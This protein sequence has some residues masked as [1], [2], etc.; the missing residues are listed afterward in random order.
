MSVVKS[1]IPGNRCAVDKTIE[2]TFM[3]LAKLNS[4]AIGLLTN[5]NA[6]Q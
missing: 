1:F 2:A 4:S 5:Y 6:Y 3:W